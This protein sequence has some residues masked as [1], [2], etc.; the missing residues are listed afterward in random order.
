MRI[1]S[2]INILTENMGC[3]CK[4]EICRTSGRRGTGTKP[5]TGKGK[6]R[7]ARTI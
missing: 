1:N 2:I 4:C 7:V 3:I 6:Q 5:K